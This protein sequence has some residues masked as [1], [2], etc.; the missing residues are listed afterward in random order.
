MKKSL[1]ILSITFLISF[2]NINFLFGQDET[3]LNIQKLIKLNNESEVKEVLIAVQD[4]VKTLMIL[5]SSNIQAGDVTIEI[6]DP[7]GEKH[8]SFSIG[9]QPVMFNKSAY[10]KG[11]STYITNADRAY[12]NL[13]RST[14]NPVKGEWK[15]KI[16]PKNA[17]GSVNLAFSLNAIIHTYTKVK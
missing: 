12:G 16:T 10:P 15:L 17:T 11:K 6:Y 7:L 2:F 4:S 14:I 3:K 9:C 13:S 8:G 1:T 5:V